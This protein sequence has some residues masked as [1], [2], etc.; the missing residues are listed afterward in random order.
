MVVISISWIVESDVLF[1][2]K[3]FRNTNLDILKFEDSS[4]S[5]ALE[6]KMNQNIDIQKNQRNQ[7][8]DVDKKFKL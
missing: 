4:N 1:N 7:G 8:C 6:N 5:E 2:A 3:N